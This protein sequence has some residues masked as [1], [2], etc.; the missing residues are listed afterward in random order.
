MLEIE[1][2]KKLAVAHSMWTTPPYY[3]ND[4][5]D[6]IMQAVGLAVDTEWEK[7][8]QEILEPEMKSPSLEQLE[9]IFLS[10]YPKYTKDNLNNYGHEANR[11]YQGFLGQSDKEENERITG[12]MEVLIQRLG[13]SVSDK[14]HRRNLQ[15]ADLKKKFD[16][17]SQAAQMRQAYSL[18]GYLMEETPVK[19][20][21]PPGLYDKLAKIRETLNY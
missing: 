13:D 10:M 4:A 1:L 3:T 16:N 6:V 18:V 15:I 14:V 5:Q 8:I 19:D 9:A 11:R 2:I 12:L 20:T 21:I 17:S 7:E